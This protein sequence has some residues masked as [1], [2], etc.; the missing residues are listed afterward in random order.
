MQ[1]LKLDFVKL[2]DKLVEELA[3]LER[4]S[5]SLDHPE[6]KSGAADIMFANCR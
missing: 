5:D 1:E 2:E 4:V 3:E 6:H